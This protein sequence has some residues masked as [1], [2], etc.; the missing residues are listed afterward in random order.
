MKVLEKYQDLD[1][2]GRPR[3]LK[4]TCW[5]R[6]IK[7]LQLVGYDYVRS[8]EAPRSQVLASVF[9]IFCSNSKPHEVMTFGIFVKTDSGA[10]DLIFLYQT[11]APTIA[12]A[13]QS[14]SFFC[15]LL[16]FSEEQ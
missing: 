4:V 13:I 15:L 10:V 2:H 9:T 14:Y 8:L 12:V 3:H 7:Y 5:S 11:A 16:I 1:D 6:R